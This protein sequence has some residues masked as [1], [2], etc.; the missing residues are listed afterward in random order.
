MDITDADWAAIINHCKSGVVVLD[1]Q[2]QVRRRNKVF[3]SFP[4]QLVE[5]I[6]SAEQQD[7]IEGY[8]IHRQTLSDG[9]ALFVHKALPSA[10][11][12]DSLLGRMLEKITHR[13][14]M[15]DAIAEAIN[16]ITGWHWVFVTRF[17]DTKNVEVLSF[18]NRDQLVAGTTYPLVDTPCEVMVRNNKYTLFTDVAD[19]F[20]KNEFL[21]VLGAKSYAG[22]VYY[23]KDHLP[24]GHIMCMHDSSDVDYRYMED[25]I[26]LASLA[27]SS[28]LLL[29]H[30]EV[31]LETAVEQAKQDSLTG[32]YNRKV[33]DEK[34]I[35]ASSDYLNEGI[36]S[37]VV[38]I[39]LNQF[40]QYNDR[41]G[42]P[43]GDILLRLFATEL[44]K[45][46]R[47]SDLAF[48]LG[49]DEF[50]LLLPNVTNESTQRVKNQLE[51]VQ[52]RLSMM[53]EKNIS[54]SIGFATLAEVEADTAKCY[55]LAD[56]RMYRQKA[57]NK[58]SMDIL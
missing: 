28:N 6:L 31:A 45:L 18:W 48:R 20:P 17:V 19:A 22:L 35:A 12:S 33:F 32:L 42:H 2:G 34:L 38:V 47:V 39:D 21:K 41:Y 46:G 10:Q 7:L 43:Q 27:I 16:D 44:A 4:D 37:S 3:L 11:H 55:D 49:G 40:K 9:E 26:K 30:V 57:N 51:G 13:D 56:Q 25:V 14:D 54:A 58:K 1:K 5:K 24:I 53:L 15:F 29:A 8:A 50:A 23:G 36:D 52:S